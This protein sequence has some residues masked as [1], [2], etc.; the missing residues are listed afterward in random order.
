MKIGIFGTGMVGET[1]AGRLVELGHEV[2]MGSRS[3]ANEKATAWVTKTG[4]RASHGTFSDAAMFGEIVFNCTQ[5][6]VSLEVLKLANG[7]QT[8]KEKILI[9]VSNPLNTDNEASTALLYCNDE[10]LGERL[11]KA[12]PDTHVVK[13]LNTMWCGIMVNPRRVKETH[14][15]YLCGNNIGAKTRV[16]EILRSF[17]WAQEEILDLGGIDA[18]RA[19]EMLLPLWQRI[20]GAT[21]SFAFNFKIVCASH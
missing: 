15:V 1:I 20:Y 5:G 21:N 14:H 3:A 7:T 12:L 17:E 9:D 10:S 16:K 2:K 18:A 13:T 11:Q 6:A 8:L 19:T 4:S